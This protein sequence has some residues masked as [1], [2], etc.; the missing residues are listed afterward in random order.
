MPDNK[1]VRLL[2]MVLCIAACTVVLRADLFLQMVEEKLAIELP[3]L[4]K[5]VDGNP[6][7]RGVGWRVWDLV[8]GTGQPAAPAAPAPT[9]EQLIRAEAQKPTDA[10]LI[11]GGSAIR[12]ELGV[13]IERDLKKLGFSKIVRRGYIS[14]GLT[15]PQVLDWTT[16]AGDLI[17]TYNPAA[18]IC[19]FGAND[20]QPISDGSGKRIPFDDPAWAA[21]YATHVDQFMALVSRSGR[22]YWLELPI[23]SDKRFNEK[24]TK[25]N[26]IHRQV[27]A[28][29]SNIRYIPTWDTFA[30]D[31]NFAPMLADS[32]GVTAAVKAADGIHFTGHGA[33]I[34]SA[35]LLPHIQEDREKLQSTGRNS[36]GKSVLSTK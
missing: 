10:I 31:G 3:G 27:S 20:G 16:E 9:P 11:L 15:D 5:A 21:V 2:A 29:Y 13:R 34:L 12:L 1:H 6:L 36:S 4:K 28:S 33:K 7:H 17:R 23:T 35:L 22:V 32:D 26:A 24:F 8:D 18:V 25:I 30:P 14:S 19:Q